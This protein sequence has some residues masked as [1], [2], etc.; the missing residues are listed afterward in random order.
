MSD[1]GDRQAM[2]WVDDELSSGELRDFERLLAA[3]P[4][5]RQV[6]VEALRVRLALRQCLAPAPRV[7]LSGVVMARIAAERR[8][9][10]VLRGAR[11]RR[12]GKPD[13]VE[14]WRRL[15]NLAACAAFL[16]LV[17]LSGGAGSVTSPWVRPAQSRPP[18]QALD[19]AS[20]AAEP[21]NVE[22][23]DFGS[24]PGTIFMVSTGDTVTPVVW[25]SDDLVASER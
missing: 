23:V 21:A 13:G 8:G 20:A 18:S 3:Q 6:L 14:R 11:G 1:R 19:V 2:S 10:R 5:R 24:R 17:S 16:M 4:A 25:L 12:L 9:L 7:D 22:L 15:S